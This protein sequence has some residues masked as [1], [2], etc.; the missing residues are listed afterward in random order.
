MKK[1]ETAYNLHT[2]SKKII[3]IIIIVSFT[4]MILVIGTLLFQF[5]ASYHE[6]V[7]D[8]LKELVEKHKQNI[9]TFLNEKAGNIRFLLKNYIAEDFETE[10][11]LRSMLTALQDEYGHIFVDLG[12]VD[13]NG[14]QVLYA[15]PYK[16]KNAVYSGADW[17]KQALKKKIYI[18]DVFTGLRGYPHFIITVTRKQNRKKLLLR[19]TIDFGAFNSLVENLRVGQTGYAFIL[20]R[21]GKYQTKPSKTLFSCQENCSYFFNRLEHS[22]KKEVL[23]EE[24]Q[25]KSGKKFIIAASLLN[26]GNW[27]MLFRQERSDAFSDLFHMQIIAGIIFLLGG[28]SIVIMAFVFSRK[29]IAQI[30]KT[31]KEIKLMNDQVV[32]S[33][34]LASVGELAAGIAHEINNPVA[35][36]VEEAGWIE[37]LMEENYGSKEDRKEI[38]RALKQI[39]IQGKRCKEI[40]HKLLSFARKTDS[41]IKDV[42]INQLVK[43]IVGFSMQIAKYNKI[44]I[45]TKLQKNLPLIKISP[46][47]IQQVLLN[48][49]NNSQ[50]AMENKGGK[51]K[52]STKM[53]KLEDDHIVIVVEDNGPGIPEANLKRIF[54]P[55]FT[56]KPVGKGTGL[57]LS[58]CYGIIQKIGG[59]IDVVSIIGKGTTFRISI[60]YIKIKKDLL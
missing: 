60:P 22:K 19:A 50:Y 5:R 7:H 21:K 1:K 42:Q 36:M 17:F 49:I 56:T 30:I 32:E 29:V 54:N 45:E 18:S 31:D 46:A 11:K 34:K 12:L 13:Q 6:K 44:I 40:T 2:L 38:Q 24:R 20:N 28:S 23:I 8:H 15:G 4:P 16:L 35:I 48:M 9:D 27:L 51:I 55:F 39:N 33:G 57:G 53:S 52:I 37:D 47:E 43:E 14:V 25:N 59:K 26:H 41:T 3:S 10:K 58:I